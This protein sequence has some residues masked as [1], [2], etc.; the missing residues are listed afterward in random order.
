L[1]RALARC[2]AGQRNEERGQ[3]AGMTR[4]PSYLSDV[5]SAAAAGERPAISRHPRHYSN[6]L[7]ASKRFAS[8]TRNARSLAARV[9]SSAVA[10]PACPIVPVAPCFGIDPVTLSPT[11]RGEK[12]SAGPRDSATKTSHRPRPFWQRFF[13]AS[14]LVFSDGHFL[15]AHTAD[16]RSVKLI[17]AVA[18]SIC[19]STMIIIN[20]DNTEKLGSS[21][22]LFRTGVHLQKTKPP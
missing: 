13:G 1:S 6:Q 19:E 15:P 21:R 3:N 4:N 7:A 5:A 9:T 8:V 12:S 2:R 16:R 10:S 11:R 18:N 17:L 14:F 22:I 20:I